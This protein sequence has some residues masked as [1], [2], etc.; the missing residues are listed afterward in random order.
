MRLSRDPRARRR[1]AALATG[2]AAAFALGVCAGADPDGE[3]PPRPSAPRP[4]PAALP[5]DEQVGQLLVSSFAQTTAPPYLVRRLRTRRTVGV[6][7]FARNVASAAQLRRLTRSLQAAA[8]GEALIAADQEGGPIRTV[9]FAGPQVGQPAQP[10]AAEAEALAGR[11]ARDLRAAGINVNLAPVAD[12]PDGPASAMWSRAFR[13]PPGR[14]AEAVRGAVRGYRSGR[15]AA[16]AKHFP[17]LGLARQNTDDAP[18][19]IDRPRASLEG[20]ELVPFR[21]AIAAGAPVVMAS[22]AFYPALDG[23]RVASQSRGVL[24]GLLR[25]QLRFEGAIVTDS[26]E[27]EAVIRGSSVEEAAERSI[28]AG[29]DIV[30]MTGAGSWNR[31]FPRLLARARADPSFRR[32]VGEAAGRVLEL[33]RRVALP[34]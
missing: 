4:A 25:D 33:K 34:G 16:T 20:A 32:R 10:G 6:V 23:A 1:L 24:Q 5:L 26:I 8:R 12:V 19:T 14:V 29:A 11:A 18:V 17:G 13:G 30:L 3:R 31:V 2:A 7:L 27:A 21:A 15:V 9:T 22:H 28:E